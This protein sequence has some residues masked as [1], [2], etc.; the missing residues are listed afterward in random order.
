MLYHLKGIRSSNPARRPGLASLAYR[1]R[2]PTHQKTRQF[3]S[4][5]SESNPGVIQCPMS[6]SACV[7]NTLGTVA[8]LVSKNLSSLFSGSPKTKGISP[9]LSRACPL[10]SLV[11]Y[12]GKRSHTSQVCPSLL[13]DLCN[14][15]HKYILLAI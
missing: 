2:T 8:F 13:M 3:N 11:S 9:L 15:L 12:A 4:A 1:N 7:W 10:W 6:Q 5:I 14:P